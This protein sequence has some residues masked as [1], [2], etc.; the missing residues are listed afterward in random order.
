MNAENREF[1]DRLEILDTGE[2]L[3]GLSGVGNPAYQYV[4]RAAAGVYWEPTLI[5]FKSTP[6]KEWSASRWFSHIVSVVRSEIGIELILADAVSWGRLS[7]TDKVEIE[8]AVSQ[9]L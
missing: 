8:Q 7:E 4:Y 1:I 2:L 3:V 6:I 5:G 9:A